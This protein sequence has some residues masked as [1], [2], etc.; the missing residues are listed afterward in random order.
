M[1]KM[2][3]KLHYANLNLQGDIPC[4]EFYDEG[5]LIDFVQ[6]IAYKGLKDKN[7]VYLIAIQDEV[8]ITD[9]PSTL[10]T[11]F[12]SPLNTANLQYNGEDIFIQGYSSFEAA[13]EVALMMKEESPLC[14][15]PDLNDN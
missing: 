3:I 10:V 7:V 13:Y 9:N 15:E 6:R 8:F 12:E 5:G 4:Y 2:H 14:Y 11:Y 1:K